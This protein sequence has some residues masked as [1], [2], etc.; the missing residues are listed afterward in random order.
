MALIS[1]ATHSQIYGRSHE[2]LQ[3]ARCAASD[4]GYDSVEDRVVI[5]SRFQ[6]RSGKKLYQWQA[7]VTEALLLGLN[8]VVIAGTGSG[9]T[10][11]FM[12]VAL[13]DKKIKIVIISPLKILQEEHASRF[14]KMGISAVP[15]NGDTWNG[16]LEESLR[17]NR[18]QVMLTSPEMCLQHP[19]F[20][21]FLSDAVI[22]GDIAMIVVDEA[23]CISQWGGD[24]RKEYSNLDKLKA[25]FP[26]HVPFLITSAT[27]NPAMLRDIQAQLNFDLDDAFFLNL[28]NDR[29]NVAMSV[30][31]INSPTDYAAILPLLSKSPTAGIPETLKDINKTIL[32]VN[33]VPIAQHCH[34]FLKA[35]LPEELHSSVEVLHAQRTRRSKRRVMK[36]FCSGEILVLVATEAAGMGADIPD[37]EQV[38]QLAV[39][40]S[41]SV[42]IQRAGRAGRTPTI[43]ARAILLVEPSVYQPIKT[44]NADDDIC[45]GEAAVLVLEWRKKV[46][47]ALRAWV[48]TT[49][50]R[51]D[52]VDDHFAN[53]P[54]RQ[55]PLGI[56]CDNCSI[57][58][59]SPVLTPRPATPEGQSPPSSCHS[60]PSR[61]PNLNGK[62]HMRHKDNL[63]NR[64]KEHLKSAQ[65][66]LIEW[67][68]ELKDRYYTPSSFTAP[69]IFPDKLLK[70]L[71]S[72]A[73]ITS[74][75]ELEAAARCRWI[76]GRRHFADALAVVRQLDVD[77]IQ[78]KEYAKRQKIELKAQ[79][80][81]VERQRKEVEKQK[82][83]DAVAEAKRLEQVRRALEKQEALLSKGLCNFE[84]PS[85]EPT[86]SPVS[87]IYE[88]SMVIK[89]TSMLCLQDLNIVL[90]I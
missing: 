9:K 80:K 32:F 60:S 39:P 68:F 37:I 63:T 62:R 43:R 38:I 52:V 87:Y 41:L 20:R 61:T 4:R 72:R 22:E 3:R 70:C 15:V 51:R 24:F 8:C 83:K 47:D 5:E 77:V 11:P 33:T 46:E 55:D 6:E 23:H 45:D 90:S 10:T 42:W 13:K 49:G 29:P 17:A 7:D 53:P 67:R 73:S 21:H 66:A 12:T 50:C 71:A 75:E 74:L 56:C 30:Q 1:P 18:Y 35:Q 59:S 57:M 64:T 16:K 58:I 82:Q 78:A 81:L 65:Q 44:S 31:N 2:N 27:L 79:E 89:S 54:G 86:S 69:G 84:T 25:F 34:R 76:V 48:E 40:S 19:G 14:K 26:T 36:K 88:V 85:L 28:G